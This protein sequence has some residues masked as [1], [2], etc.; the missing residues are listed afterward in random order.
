ML[1]IRT[2]IFT[3]L[4][5]GSVAAWVPYLLLSSGLRASTHHL[6]SFRFLG[7]LTV[8]FGA[9]LYV[10][11]AA[12]FAFAGEGTPAPWDPPGRVVAGGL[13]RR[14]RNPMYLAIGSVLLGEAILFESLPL[15]AYSSLIGALFHLFVVC[16]E[17]PALKRKFGADYEAYCRAVPRWLPWTR[18][19]NRTG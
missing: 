11:C 2:L 7:L 13:Y 5:P 10:W 16:Y 8:V 4:V 3:V 9:A 17:E 15:L 19:G 1:V 6:G 12:E 14:T 18:R